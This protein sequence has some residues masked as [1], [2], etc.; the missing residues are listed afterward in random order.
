MHVHL[1]LPFFVFR[2]SRF[3]SYRL[4]CM[5]NYWHIASCFS[6]SLDESTLKSHSLNSFSKFLL[7]PCE[8]TVKYKYLLISC[9]LF[10]FSV[11]DCKSVHFNFL[12]KEI[13]FQMFLL[14]K[15]AIRGLDDSRHPENWSHHIVWFIQWRWSALFIF[16]RNF[17]LFHI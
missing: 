13:F 1:M 4:L 16:S 9:G 15:I 7:K 2:L 11:L 5:T 14:L 8:L 10:C 6:E 3:L 12:K 17:T